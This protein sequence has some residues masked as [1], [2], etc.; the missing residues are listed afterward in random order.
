MRLRTKTNM[1]KSKKSSF[2]ETQSNTTMENTPSS[3]NS[4]TDA[5][6]VTP[7]TNQDTPPAADRQSQLATILIGLL[8]IGSGLLLYNYFQ[9][10]STPATTKTITDQTATAT[11]TVTPTSSPT[12]TS[13]PTSAKTTPT[14]QASPKP[15]ASPLAKTTPTPA[16]GQTNY[17][18]VAGDSLWTVAEKVY[19]NGFDWQKI[20]QANHI[21]SNAQGQPEVVV[22]QQLI[23]PNSAA[24]IAQVTPTPQSSSQGKIAQAPTTTLQQTPTTAVQTYTVQH[25]DSLWSIA[26]SHYG[27]GDKWI[28]IYN[29]QHNQLGKLPDGTPLIHAGNVLYL[30]SN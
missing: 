5:N 15:T 12:P 21:T 14:P 18:V 20:Q 28:I 11:P 24:T 23:I 10:A 6:P 27:S 13:T 22:G 25:G 26:E 17:T 4:S 29:D 16:S 2:N 9:N 8:I 30:P 7:K 3:A 1:A 19:G